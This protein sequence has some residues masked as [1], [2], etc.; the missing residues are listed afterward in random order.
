M[1]EI[2]ENLYSSATLISSEKKN[3]I[4]FHF[5][6]IR[7]IWE[8]LILF[9]S[10]FPLF[11]VPF[12][13]LFH[14]K[15]GILFYSFFLVHDILFL[16]D[17]FIVTHTAYLSHGILITDPKRII[18]RYGKVSFYI[19]ILGALPISWIGIFFSN[20]LIYFILSLNRFLRLK[21]ALHSMN[22]IQRSLIYSQWASTIIPLLYI[23]IFFIHFFACLFYLSAKFEGISA[24]WVGILKWDSLSPP[25]QY[26][27]SIYFVM[28]TILTI[29]FGD[30]T[31]QTSTETIL[32]IIIQLIGVLLNS[33]I[34]GVLVMNLIDPIKT[35]FLKSFEGLADYLSFKKI[36]T[37]LKH[38]IKDYFQL[39][40]QE[41]NGTED[42]NDV[43]K[44]LP[45]TIKDKLQ[46]D[47]SRTVINKISL[48]QASNEK[49]LIAISDTL[50]SISFIP[51][52]NIITFGEMKSEL[53]LLNSGTIE[54]YIE[55]NLVLTKNCQFGEYFG[56]KE[57][58]IDQRYN[59]TVKSL[60]HVSGWILT[61]ENLLKCLSHRP[62]LK[63]KLLEASKITYPSI[64][65]EIRKLVSTRNLISFKENY[66]QSLRPKLIHKLSSSSSEEDKL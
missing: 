57:L 4:F 55:N 2:N 8:Y 32:V 7:Q 48:F 17:L 54:I 20:P 64:Y 9:I 65:K 30:L 31:P 13:S 12:I 33:Y 49:L 47:L 18:K 19:H 25:Q 40:W 60:T 43:F 11:E 23:L 50:E 62:K 38:D 66:L 53:I 36:P 41:N 34:V 52:E 16:I 28:T 46:L 10:A 37:N 26:V 44:Y 42:P 5:S 27:V 56:E 24:S 22:T 14:P 51:G 3:Y 61:R 21:R 1:K 58:F 39:K 35:Q 45:Q 15:I 59:I 63:K 29:G 6:T